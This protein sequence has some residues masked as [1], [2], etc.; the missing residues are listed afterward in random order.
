MMT[1]YWD[2]CKPSCGWNDAPVMANNEGEVL[3]TCTAVTS[4]TFDEIVEIDIPWA[5]SSCEGGPAS[6]CTDQLPW[7]EGDTLYG[8]VANQDTGDKADCGTC[9]EL[10]FEDATGSGVT[11][12]L[13]Q[14]TNKGG[15]GSDGPNK[16]VFDLAVPGGGFGDFDG[17]TDVPG[18]TVYTEDGGPC[19]QSGDT[20]SCWRYGGFGDAA[21]C[22]ESFHG[23]P[24][25]QQ[26]CE[27]VLFGFFPPGWQASGYVPRGNTKVLAR[28][29][30]D[31]PAELTSKSGISGAG[32]G[33]TSDWGR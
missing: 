31:C 2:C 8:Y 12:G 22:G 7:I 18:W 26:A 1:H 23:D 10:L 9:Y 33:T 4:G 19:S 3:D 20:A 6:M 29:V 32:G 25:S 28:R 5:A 24:M 27:D 21:L 15:M 17:C 14:V 11:R 16:A 30:I 13:V